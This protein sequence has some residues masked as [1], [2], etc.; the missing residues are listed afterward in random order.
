[1]TSPTTPRRGPAGARGTEC[2]RAGAPCGGPT[3]LRARSAW[4]DVTRTGALTGLPEDRPGG[5]AAGSLAP[6]TLRRIIGGGAAAHNAFSRAAG[7]VRAAPAALSSLAAITPEP[8]NLRRWPTR[9][10]PPSSVPA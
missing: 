5:I 9:S 10:A 6:V 2:P 3:H 4:L 1:M 7:A 8:G